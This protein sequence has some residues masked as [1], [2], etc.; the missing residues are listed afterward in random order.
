LLVLCWSG[1]RWHSPLLPSYSLV[2]CLHT[3][4]VTC[5]HTCAALACLARG[6]WA[7]CAVAESYVSLSLVIRENSRRVGRMQL[8]V[9]NVKVYEAHDFELETAQFLPRLFAVRYRRKATDRRRGRVSVRNPR[10]IM[11][12]QLRTMWWFKTTWQFRTTGSPRNLSVDTAAEY[13]V[14]VA[15]GS[16]LCQP[17]YRRHQGIILLRSN[18]LCCTCCYADGD[19]FFFYVRPPYVLTLFDYSALVPTVSPYF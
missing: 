3:G 15:A 11:M 9:D 10:F 13:L 4:L 8:L 17:S 7:G 5:L 1:L 16:T 14:E 18:S 6:F 12:W 19:C 2:T